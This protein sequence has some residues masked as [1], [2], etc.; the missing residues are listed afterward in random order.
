MRNALLEFA[1]DYQ[2]YKDSL[3]RD[4]LLVMASP[5]LIARDAELDRRNEDIIAEALDNSG[6][7]PSD[8][9]LLAG[10]IFGGIRANL[11]SWYTGGCRRDLTDM[12]QDLLNLL[13]TLDT[14][15]A[16]RQ[17]RTDPEGI[18]DTA[19]GVTPD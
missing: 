2:H 12:G 14:W 4:W 10:V 16:T 15:L 7:A 18:E 5:S 8:S 9:R 6:V 19:P 13:V 17:R 11:H 3:Y 1:S